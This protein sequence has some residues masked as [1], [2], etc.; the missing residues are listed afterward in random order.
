MH[1]KRFM[2]IWLELPKVN[3]RSFFGFD[4][5]LWICFDRS[6]PNKFELLKIF[7]RIFDFTDERRFMIEHRMTSLTLCSSQVN[8][9]KDE[10]K[11]EK[12]SIYPIVFLQKI[13]IR[14]MPFKSLSEF[15]VNKRLRCW[16]CVFRKNSCVSCRI[17]RE[18]FQ[19]F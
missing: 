10:E 13:N 9:G 2:Y 3:F 7:L 4:W 12:K 6:F 14:S 5:F 11:K 19:S 18:K 15:S 1:C 17:I 16:C 8:G